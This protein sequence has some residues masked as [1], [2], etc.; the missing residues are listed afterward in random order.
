MK[1]I[2]RHLQWQREKGKLYEHDKKRTSPSFRARDWRVIRSCVHDQVVGLLAF[3]FNEEFS[4]L[5]VDVFTSAD[6]PD[7]E[8]GHGSRGLL[9]LLLSEAYRNGATMEIRFTRYDTSARRRVPDR[10]RVAVSSL[11]GNFGIKLADGSAG[12]ISHDEAVELYAAVVGLKN[13][14]REVV[15]RYQARGRL[16]LQGLCYL[17][18]ARIWSPEE[19]SWI[20]LNSA[21]PDAVLFGTQPED[22]FNYMSAV[23]Y[24]RASL[25]A[26]RLRQKLEAN[27]QETEGDCVVQ[28][29]GPLWR[30]RPIRSSILDWESRG[31][32]LSISPGDTLT[33]LTSPRILLPGQEQRV[34]DDCDT[35]TS[36]CL[37]DNGKFLLYSVDLMAFDRLN[38]IA[39]RLWNTSKVRILILPWNCKEL[40]EEVERRMS[41]ARIL[42]T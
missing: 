11:A 24:G 15:S 16:T 1:R 26:T 40:D 19:V 9:L 8:A 12:V 14:V 31:E 27:E 4:G 41:K 39:S 2:Q 23:A 17:L 28:V 42:R 38:D 34:V 13:E 5:E 3:R 30:M 29:D 20:L 37:N 35:L 21:R 22:R 6:H 18:G 25:A 7:Y 36:L 10:M 32:K 33:V